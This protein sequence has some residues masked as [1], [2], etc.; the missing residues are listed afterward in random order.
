M[1]FQGQKP[2]GRELWAGPP[3]ATNYKAKAIQIQFVELI[4]SNESN[5]QATDDHQC[6]CCVVGLVSHSTEQQL[7]TIIAISSIL[8]TVVFTKCALPHTYR[9][10]L[11]ERKR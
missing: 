8:H 2:I 5:K 7:R 6:Y 1:V 11:Q 3:K 10:T 4:R 9:N